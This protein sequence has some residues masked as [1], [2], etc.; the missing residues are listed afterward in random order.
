LASTPSGFD[1]LPVHPVAGGMVARAL[2]TTEMD[3][4]PFSTS[5]TLNRLPK[6]RVVT[7]LQHS[8]IFLI[9]QKFADFVRDQTVSAG[10]GAAAI[11]FG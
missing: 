7:W 3:G 8:L 4:Q 6:E 2:V 11:P 9:V 5:Q 1:N 10:G